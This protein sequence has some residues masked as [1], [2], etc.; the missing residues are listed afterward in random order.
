MVRL[1]FNW[2]MNIV[3]KLFSSSCWIFCF[4]H[5]LIE[6]SSIWQFTETENEI[7]LA[8]FFYGRKKFKSFLFGISLRKNVQ[9]FCSFSLRSFTKMDWS[10]LG[11]SVSRWSSTRPVIRSA[12]EQK[13]NLTT[14]A[15]S[16]WKQMDSQRFPTFWFNLFLFSS[17]NKS[18]GWIWNIPKSFCCV[19][20][21]ISEWKFL[22]TEVFLQIRVEKTSEH[23]KTLLEF[24]PSGNLLFEWKRRMSNRRAAEKIFSFRNSIF[25]ENLS[26]Q[27][28]VVVWRQTNDQLN[29]RKLAE[30]KISPRICFSQDSLTKQKNEFNFNQSTN[31]YL[32]FSESK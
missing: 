16:R 10:K 26:I 4:A 8:Q 27:L 30:N 21:H 2:L 32:T 29:T 14:S 5:L 9:F 24:R 11:I 7:F 31:N 23:T 6:K 13:L 1:D 20:Q 22:A 25:K 15:A 18:S 19:F 28:I 3:T 17:R 12:L